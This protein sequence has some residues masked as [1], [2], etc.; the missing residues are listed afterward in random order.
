MNKR[1]VIETNRPD[2]NPHLKD[3]K[4]TVSPHGQKRKSKFKREL[5]S[6]KTRTNEPP[7]LQ[8]RK[9][10]PRKSSPN[11]PNAKK[12]LNVQKTRDMSRRD[13]LL[14]KLNISND[15]KYKLGPKFDLSDVKTRRKM[16]T[17]AKQEHIE[18]S[19]KPKPYKSYSK[20]IA[21]TGNSADQNTQQPIMNIK[22]GDSYYNRLNQAVRKGDDPKATEVPP[23]SWFSKGSSSMN[24]TKGKDVPGKKSLSIKEVPM[25]DN[26]RDPNAMEDDDFLLPSKPQQPQPSTNNFESQIQKAKERYKDNDPSM[27]A[28]QDDGDIFA[29]GMNHDRTDEWLN[30]AGVLNNKK[31]EQNDD[32]GLGGI[33]GGVV[34]AL[35][36]GYDTWVSKPTQAWYEWA[37]DTWN[38]ENN[39]P[40]WQHIGDRMWNDKTEDKKRL[41]RDIEQ[42]KKTGTFTPNYDSKAGMNPWNS[43][44]N[45]SNAVRKNNKNKPTKKNT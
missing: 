16:L 39:K 25:Q 4:Y 40:L 33:I 43:F 14:S 6:K 44:W 31:E 42:Y 37:K 3:R 20:S 15:T 28:M 30:N 22:T 2:F 12:S 10:R 21:E 35:K 23:K 18:R 8:K 5:L 34:D 1:S 17:D 29:T 32:D 41:I 26:F 27:D 9:D 38:Q 24:N 45:K 36:Y 13:K 19:K 7:I 11:Q